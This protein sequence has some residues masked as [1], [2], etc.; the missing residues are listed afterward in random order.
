MVLLVVL[1]LVVLL[2]ALV[3]L[4]VLPLYCCAGAVR[5]LGLVVE[6][7]VAPGGRG[8][9]FVGPC[10]VRGSLQ[11]TLLRWATHGGPDACDGGKIYIPCTVLSAGRVTL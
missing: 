6:L 2:V 1:L 9:W 5:V 4:L 3:L 7:A 11:P 8:T 10:Q